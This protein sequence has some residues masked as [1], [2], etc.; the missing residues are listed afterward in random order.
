[1]GGRAQGGEEVGA[2]QEHA[3][4]RLGGRPTQWRK[5][6]APVNDSRVMGFQCA[7]HRHRDL[8][9]IER[10]HVWPLGE[11]GPDTKD[12]I[13]VVCSNGHE[14]IHHYIRELLK[15]K[16][17]PPWEVSIRYGRKVR[18]LGKLGYNRIIRQAM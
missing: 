4:E 15:H 5:A 10:H 14:L 12:N 6:G 18:I 9:P 1:M 8:V 2:Q 7:V 16:G 11:G 17:S 3:E 13:V